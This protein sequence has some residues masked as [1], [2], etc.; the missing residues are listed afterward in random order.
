MGVECVMVN[1]EPTGQFAHNPEP[2][3]SNLVE[4]SE[5]VVRLKVDV[6]GLLEI[7]EHDEMKPIRRGKACF[8]TNVEQVGHFSH[9]CLIKG[10]DK[11]RI[12]QEFR[13]LHR[14]RER[15]NSCPA[16][17]LIVQVQQ[18]DRTDSG[19]SSISASGCEFC[20]DGVGNGT[21]DNAHNKRIIL[22]SQ[23]IVDS[24]LN[25]AK[26]SIEL[27]YVSECR[28]DLLFGLSALY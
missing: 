19:T 16:M 6:R 7:V 24:R 15:R 27:F 4:L 2:L 18:I 26:E 23:R 21:V 17:V 25:H 28:F 9:S 14:V 13:I 10:H 12:A 11:R 3:P 20:V 22:Y 1:C 8:A 5:A